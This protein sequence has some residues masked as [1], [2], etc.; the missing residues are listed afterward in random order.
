[1]VFDRIY[2]FCRMVFDRMV[3]DRIYWIYRM[4]WDDG[5]DNCID[6]FWEASHPQ[7]QPKSRDKRQVGEADAIL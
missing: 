4:G 1:M 2:R 6:G 5:G 3:F 7:N